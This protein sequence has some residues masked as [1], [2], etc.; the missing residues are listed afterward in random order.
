MQTKHEPKN[1]TKFGAKKCIIFCY[2][3]W[4]ALLLSVYLNDSHNY[5]LYY[6]KYDEGV[7]QDYII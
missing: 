1:A 7:I 4:N 6:I 3:I 5:A 2:K